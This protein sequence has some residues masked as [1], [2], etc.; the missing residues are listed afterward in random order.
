YLACESDRP[1][2]RAALAGLF[3]PEQA[4]AQA[5]R[6]LTQALVRLREAL[7]PAGDSLHAARQEVQWRAAAADVDVVE[8]ARLARSA[9][10]SDLA[11]AAAL[12]RGEFLAGFALPGCEAFE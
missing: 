11:R 5:L 7:G 9:E 4:E 6:N 1:H 8:F 12:Y 10:T 3:W 2:A